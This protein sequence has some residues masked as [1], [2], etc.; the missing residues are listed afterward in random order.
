MHE[1][2]VMAIVDRADAT[3]EKI[4]VLASGINDQYN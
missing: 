2:K 4:A 1:G 3:E